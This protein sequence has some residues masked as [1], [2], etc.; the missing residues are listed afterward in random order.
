MWNAKELQISKFVEAQD[1]LLPRFQRKSTWNAKKDFLLAL[2][3]FRGLPLGAIVIKEGA[4]GGNRYLLDG[5]QRWEALKGIQDP[6]TV[7]GWAKSALGIRRGWTEQQLVA[8][9]R[10]AVED[11]FGADPSD[12]S[13]DPDQPAPAVS[14]VVEEDEESDV[15]QGPANAA[16]ANEGTEAV[17]AG[18]KHQG[19]EEL[20]E[21]LLLVHPITAKGSKLAGAFSFQDLVA[22]VPFVQ[23]DPATGKT[24]VSSPKLREWI[25]FRRK[26]ASPS[27]T[28]GVPDEEEFFTWVT[29]GTP[30]DGTASSA[31]KNRITTNWGLIRS[32]IDL[33]RRIEQ[34]LEQSVI[35]ALV[36]TGTTASEDAKIFEIIN[37]GGTKLTAAEVL[38]ASP[39]WNTKVVDPNDTL[40]IDAKDL[41]VAMGIQDED[42]A[43]RW[44]VPAT[45]LSR[46]LVPDVLGSLLGKTPRNDTR[47]FER[48]ITLGFQ[49]MAGWYQGKIAK[50]FV[51]TLPKDKP[52]IPWGTTEFERLINDALKHACNQEQ[53][54]YW[55]AWG[56][57][58]IDLMSDA[59]ALNYSLL[60]AI[61]WDR[62]DRP[63]VDGAQM[64]AFRRNARTLLDRVIYEY[65]VGQW[66]GSS[67][68]RIAGNIAALRASPDS[69]FEPVSQDD[70]ARLVNEVVE[71][72][73]I[74]GAD[75][76][77][78][79]D[80]RIKLLIAYRNVVDRLWPEHGQNA[81]YEFDHIVPSSEFGA[82]PVASP[83]KRMEHHIL[84]L[85]MLPPTLNRSK[86]DQPLK[87]VKSK[88]DKE[89]IAYF[90]GIPL[91]RFAEFSSGEGVLGLSDV[92]GPILTA[93]LTSVRQ[94]RLE[95]ASST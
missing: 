65:C 29:S 2:S 89:R 75:Y 72:G 71:D 13:E 24:V 19:I 34:R 47:R 60:M 66:R 21:I 52:E 22:G 44:D 31:L 28:L 80:P 70:W 93:A 76:T 8:A 9:Y 17:D 90:E 36:L 91:D 12:T 69:A 59:V 11:Y 57:S 46:L 68:S 26:I 27:A 63:T 6:E 84:N 41:Y 14:E 49:L 73:T 35:A 48:R 82:I 16:S 54:Q 7:Y 61:D 81:G 86:S 67:D 83:K 79:L 3:F 92:R 50:D 58:V 39:Q 85:A 87:R 25:S 42:D 95:V 64:K 56:L 78:R 62:K 53:F 38:S 94:H 88:A 45:L 33:N 15:D 5:R 37:T 1:L 10:K 18:A 55:H 32:A 23:K 30:L 77:A 4:P 51:E 74:S 40:L 20:L 43:V